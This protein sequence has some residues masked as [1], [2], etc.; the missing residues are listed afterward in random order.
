MN[1]NCSENLRNYDDRRDVIVLRDLNFQ[2]V[3]RPHQNVKPGFW[4]RISV[5]CKPNHVFKILPRNV[6]AA[7]DNHSGMKSFSI[8]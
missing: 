4:W 2:I 1:L 7:S 5:D 3:F 8:L 6:D